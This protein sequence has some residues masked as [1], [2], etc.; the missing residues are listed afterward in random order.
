M[1]KKRRYRDRAAYI[2]K[3][4]TKRRKKLRQK[5][6]EYKGGEC[7]SCGYKRFVG[8]LEFHHLNEKKKDFGISLKGLT[9]SWVRIKKEVDKCILVC[10]NCHREIHGRNLK[11]RG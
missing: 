2:I 3:A 4:V 5:A 11:I 7:Q 6:I 10:S 1:A 9:R 8:A